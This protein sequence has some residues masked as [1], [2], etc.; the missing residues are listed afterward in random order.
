MVLNGGEVVLDY[1]RFQKE[2]GVEESVVGLLYI[3]A[4]LLHNIRSCECRKKVALF[5]ECSPPSLDE[6]LYHKD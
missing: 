5:F 3:T 1:N 6:D 4:V 2:T